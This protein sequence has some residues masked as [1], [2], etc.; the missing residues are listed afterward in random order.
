MRVMAIANQKG[1]VGKTATVLNLGAALAAMGERVIL[2]DLDPQ[3]NLTTIAGVEEVELSS[4][5]LLLSDDIELR[6]VVQSTA[7]DN[8]LIMPAEDTLA[9]AEVQLAD[10]PRRQDRLRDKLEGVAE[11]TWVLIDTP[12]SLGSLTI[13][14]LTAATDALIPVQCSY[15]AMQGLRGLLGTIETVRER[16]NP[17][18]RLL[19]V[20]L[21]MYDG[22]TRH[23]RQV[24][25]RLTE[26]FGKQVLK[27]MIPRSVA[28]DYATVAAQPLVHFRGASAGADAYRKLAR[29]VRK[30]A[31]ES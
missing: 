13:N 18:L 15:L 31:K 3:A 24:V 5:D 11:D 6:D 2:V 20:L 29:E 25:E 10:V 30:R 1:G 23:S 21:T 28:F 7:Y 4:Y 26:H 14:A 27:T 19:G 17:D 16:S 9:A 22:R 8:L 12:P